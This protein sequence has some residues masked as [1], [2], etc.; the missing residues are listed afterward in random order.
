MRRVKGRAK[1]NA[2]AAVFAAIG[3]RFIS[4]SFGSDSGHDTGG[5]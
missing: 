4:F 5:A 2:A 3:P 1:I